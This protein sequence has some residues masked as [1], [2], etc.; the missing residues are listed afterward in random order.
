MSKEIYYLEKEIRATRENWGVAK[1][2]MHQG[3][4]EK[5]K[6][7]YEIIKIEVEKSDEMT[8]I[9]IEDCNSNHLYG[10]VKI[11]SNIESLRKVINAVRSIEGYNDEILFDIIWFI[12]EGEQIEITDNVVYF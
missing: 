11:N 6:E 12:F 5:V 8:E 7:G 4:S 1:Y 3:K 2:E 9:L 10:I